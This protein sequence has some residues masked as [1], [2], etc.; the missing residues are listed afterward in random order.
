[1]HFVVNRLYMDVPIESIRQ[2]ADQELL[3]LFTAVR[4]EYYTSPPSNNAA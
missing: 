2:A 1:M 4:Q 3:P